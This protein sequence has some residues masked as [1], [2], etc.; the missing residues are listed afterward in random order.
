M[1][2][3]GSGRSRHGPSKYDEY[4][5]SGGSLV[6]K[7]G[8]G[9]ND[10]SELIEGTKALR[11]YA[12]SEASKSKEER[13]R[14]VAAALKR[15]GIDVDTSADSETIVAQLIKQ[16][17]NPKNG[18]SFSNEA[19]A[20]EKVCKVVAD[21]LN[22]EFTPG[23]SRNSHK[24]I[25]T[26]LGAVEVCRAVGEWAH[27]FAV[28]INTEFMAVHASVKNTLRAIKIYDEIM[29]K[30][31]NKMVDRVHKRG[32]EQL[33][34][35]LGPLGEVYTRAQNARRLA[36]ET[37]S[38]L[39]HVKLA[40][41]ARELEIAMR[42]E[43]ETNAL[44]K[45]LGVKPGT[46]AF[47]DTLAMSVSSIGTT[48]AIASK[49]HKAL[50]DVGVSLQQYLNSKDYRDLEK[51]LDSKVE[52]NEV[53]AKDLS[54]FLKAVE[55]LRESFGAPDREKLRDALREDIARHGGYDSD[56]D[57]ENAKKR[58]RY[59]K[60]ATAD[61][62]E[63]RQIQHDFATRMARHYDELLAAVKALGPELGDKIPISDRTDALRDALQRVSDL[64]ADNERIEL[65]LIGKFVGVATRETKEKFVNALQAVSNACSA[66]LELE[67]YRSVSSY[68]VRLKA[69]IDSIKKT[70]DFYSDVITKKFGG[71]DVSGGCD[72]SYKGG[73]DQDLPEI[74]RSGLSLTTS[75]NEFAY[76]YYVSKVRANLKQTSA[77]LEG[78]G[79]KYTELL[80]DAVAARLYALEQERIAII[81]QLTEGS[82]TFQ[83]VAWLPG[84]NATE[85]QKLSLS[86]LKKAV[87]V[88]YDT[89]IGFYRVLQGIDLYMKEFTSHITKDPDAVKEIKKILDG[90]P[91]IARWFSE[92]TGDALYK[93]F[94]GM[95]SADGADVVAAAALGT[96][97]HDAA[98]AEHYY[99]KIA[100]AEGAAVANAG[101][102]GIPQVGVQ[103]D[104]AEKVKKDV[105]SVIDN[106]QALKNLV[107][108][109]LR[110]GDVY[111]GSTL[112]QK[113]FL[114]PSE[115]YRYLI[116][117][118]KNSAMSVNTQA[119][120]LNCQL[121]GVAIAN[122]V[123][124][125]G[126]Y[127][128][129]V[130]GACSGNYKL[131][132]KYFAYTIKAMAAKILTV[133]GV[134]DLFE[135]TSP[136]YELTATRM[137]IGGAAENDPDVLE[138]A[139]ELYF[140]L[141][142]LAEFYRSYLR[143]KEANF[144]A[145]EYKIAM[146][147]DIDGTF[148]NLIQFIFV[149][150]ETAETGDYSDSELRMLI[151]IINNV[152]EFYQEKHPGQATKMALDAF[153]AEI[154]RRYG[155]LKKEDVAAYW[156]LITPRALTGPEQSILND[157]NYAILPEE[158]SIDSERLAP[159]DRFTVGARPR[160]IN[161]EP[162]NPATGRPFNA[163]FANQ[164][165]IANISGDVG[166][167]MLRGFR[168]KLDKD[169]NRT[170]VSTAFGKRQYALLLQ[171]AEA[172]LRKTASR[173]ERLK[174][175]FRLIQVSPVVSMDAGKAF[176][177]NETVVVGLNI[178]SAIESMLRRYSNAL[179]VMDPLKIERAI[180][181][182]LYLNTFGK[183]FNAAGDIIATPAA[184]AANR[185]DLLA[186]IVER[187]P[188]SANDITSYELSQDVAAV[189]VSKYDRYI[190]GG[191]ALTS[192]GAAANKVFGYTRG[193]PDV[194]SIDDILT[195]AGA[196]AVDGLVAAG[197][198]AAGLGYG[199]CNAAGDGNK[200]L[201]SD[202]IQGYDDKTEGA[203][204]E[205]ATKS[206]ETL[207][208]KVNAANIVAIRRYLQ[209]LRA[210]SRALTDYQLIM[211]DFVEFLFELTSSSS[212]LVGIQFSSTG[213]VLLD[214][215][216]LRDL[217]ESLLAD[218]KSY[219]EQFRSS[220]SK[221]AVKRFESKDSAGS[222]FWIEENLIDNIF[223]AVNPDTTTP[224]AKSLDG[225]SER[226]NK[227]FQGLNRDT[228]VSF[229]A[230]AN[231][232]WI[233]GNPGARD[234]VMALAG[235]ANYRRE[236]YGKTFSKLVYY[237]S[238]ANYVL[239]AGG[240]R[241]A[242][243]RSGLDYVD[244]QVVAGDHLAD[245]T[246]TARYPLI[247]LMRDGRPDPRNANLK[248]VRSVTDAA[249]P[250]LAGAAPTTTT[251]DFGL[252]TQ[253]SA[254][255]LLQGARS[256][257]FSFNQ[258]L[259]R[260]LSV[261]TDSAGGQ[262][263]YSQLIA[264]LANGTLSQS[265]MQPLGSAFPDIAGGAGGVVFG[266]R[267][268]PKPNALLFQSL[269]FILQ[270]LVKDVNPQNQI[271]DHLFMTLTDVPMYMKE[272][273]RANLP[274][275]AK[276]FD[277]LIQKGEF[278][279][280]ILQVRDVVNLTRPAQTA[281]YGVVGVFA[282]VGA[283]SSSTIVTADNTRG[284]VA[285]YPA[286][287]LNA[288]EDLTGTFGNLAANL[289]APT[290]KD[291]SDAMRTKLITII[292]NISAAAYTTST[293]ANEVLK[294]LGDAPIYMQ[295]QEG[296]FETYK[297]RY[298]K[299]PMTPIS[300]SLWFLGDI[301]RVSVVPF[302]VGSVADYNDSRL[303]PNKTLGTAEFK[304]LYGTRQLLAQS[305][306]V[307]W[308]QLV[309]VKSIVDQYN[310]GNAKRD[311][312]DVDGYLKF[313][314]NVVK[315]LR[316][317]TDMRNYKPLISTSNRLQIGTFIADAGAAKNVQSIIRNDSVPALA[318]MDMVDGI[319]SYIPATAAAAA[320]GSATWALKGGLSARVAQFMA[321]G[322]I[323]PQKLP[324]D[325]ANIV[326]NSNQEDRQKEIYSQI[327]AA[328]A[329][330]TTN[331][332]L[333]L[334]FNIIDMNIIPFN[335]H[336]M[337]RDIP[338]A[339]IYNYEYTFEQMVCSMYGRQA[340][341]LSD[342]AVTTKDYFLQLLADPYMTVSAEN[343]GSDRTQNG[344]AGF[345]GRIFRGDNDLG[346]GR[347][348]FLSD[349]LYNK[350]L[351]RSVYQSKNDYDEGGPTVG[352]GAARGRNAPELLGYLQ[353][354]VVA[355][356][357]AIATELAR[358]NQYT[359][360]QVRANM[361]AQITAVY[362]GIGWDAPL[363]AV[364]PQITQS[365][366][367]N[368]P[369]S[370]RT[371]ADLQNYLKGSVGSAGK[372][373]RIVIDQN[374]RNTFMINDVMVSGWLKTIAVELDTGAIINADS[375][376][377]LG[378]NAAAA[379]RAAGAGP[380]AGLHG[381]LYPIDPVGGPAAGA[382]VIPAAGGAA[383]VGARALIAATIAYHRAILGA[384]APA[385]ATYNAVAGGVAVKLSEVVAAFNAV[386]TVPER[387]A[388]EEWVLQR[389]V[390][391]VA[392]YFWINLKAAI[393]AFIAASGIERSIS[394][395]ISK[396][397]NVIR[398][399]NSDVNVDATIKARLAIL[400]ARFPIM[401]IFPSAI[402][403]TVPL[404]KIDV[405]T[406]VVGAGAANRGYTEY[407]PGQLT[408]L[409]NAEIAAPNGL[410][411]V[412]LRNFPIN[413]R[414]QGLGQTT[415]GGRSRKLTYIGTGD[416]EAAVNEV[417]LTPAMNGGIQSNKERLEAIG[418]A[419]FDTYLV[420][421]LFFITN[422]VRVI[423]AKLS[424]ELTQSRNVLIT[425][426]EAVA[427]SYTEYGSDPY[428]PNEVFNSTFGPSGTTARFNDKERI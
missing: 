4:Y 204:E 136:L 370:I 203:A 386:A 100:V 334:L 157:T 354:M 282:G 307:S 164:E 413:N 218:V 73:D 194:S 17:P 221:E 349:Q 99:Q 322:E 75:V 72:A 226:T 12:S 112:R 84:A 67:L 333:E 132:S 90:V 245:V 36:E 348:K 239:T 311:Q 161:G 377:Q 240:A 411:T 326:E 64:R 60:K 186:R 149:R 89:K 145:M 172:D 351:L 395:T 353:S 268:D 352:I 162:I 323:S 9:A 337:M 39:L 247:T 207:S 255:V 19:K 299:A 176:M 27:A 94:E 371:Y 121:S 392:T 272:A 315:G 165:A 82:P 146:L 119:A 296:A 101:L 2:V 358:I 295:T 3:Y 369:A 263:I 327:V 276:L 177:F 425:D 79:E 23:E 63:K 233:A 78:Y 151:S 362:A 166:R 388:G 128:G 137:I 376:M 35:E 105:S 175:A 340:S 22:D 196:E 291:V 289:P 260:Y 390:R 29:S 314:Q 14:R 343:Y 306:Q 127:F 183:S 47:A 6:S 368:A 213:K 278:I 363:W 26:S 109:F 258:L 223:N 241:V 267:G 384:R 134:Y 130:T 310:V 91:V 339:N 228:K 365:L 83:G 277:L 168:E 416:R 70:I 160:F 88:E 171:Q 96:A 153:V 312:V 49:V 265:V 401:R 32:D 116:D 372:G 139:A 414:G 102:L 385:L 193:A 319:A 421:N 341:K 417:V 356:P 135:R 399:W 43:S 393:I 163:P 61:M 367:V 270:R 273:Y 274:G 133:I 154:N 42:D 359:L 229:L 256:L 198:A 190:A 97:V 148:A 361:A 383:A 92:Q 174:I 248:F 387:N 140:R 147:P 150:S 330:G 324:E 20:Q 397:E 50:T 250:V 158:D 418:K 292:D 188:T 254:G 271:S 107:N 262:R 103:I 235:D 144:G 236:W 407:A 234:P 300:L 380:L 62:S 37:L 415:L 391:F 332:D 224:S 410:L 170:D 199:F 211:Q 374:L 51:V 56:E 80:G 382:A 249:I 181:D 30:Y 15:T 25:D 406:N 428:G 21:V 24:L 182:T 251:A 192:A 77:E 129:S 355:G 394:D 402:N 373:T 108:A 33:G 201:P 125:Y 189:N 215:K 34:S 55:T 184:G 10:E 338:L 331:R 328:M 279:K 111:G 45:K 220:L 335:V 308:D 400:L 303:F 389:A 409:I 53:S 8:G 18:K 412:A 285:D 301:E 187:I 59:E 197:A 85:A 54:K 214:F 118:V 366:M 269:A 44:V 318:N 288:L 191:A 346:M 141:P 329:A 208:S 195:F 281:G 40:P 113:S 230:A 98:G 104:Q 304:L 95:G 93:A 283:V 423:R 408:A 297:I 426:H 244:P 31:Y 138:G 28:G 231:A 180:M 71:E 167:E 205:F 65:A 321:A 222:I 375:D 427:S 264:G 286:N 238:G 403:A 11:E 106:F 257:M 5:G 227:V 41:A 290:A 342:T 131:E 159:S 58:S 293:A 143:T 298:G 87:L 345:V 52:N 206:K 122:S 266:A 325:I 178:L 13:I 216:K 86:K 320:R 313:I 126:S 246:N 169:F 185:A 350:S 404:A 275:F 219:F 156:K 294:E 237:D 424:R 347:P 114:K 357:N 317:L 232:A 1:E 110:I 379:A 152:F 209:A 202:F 316:F 422:V 173:E 76:F 81:A 7:R 68:F 344:S 225:I 212:G 46:G 419:R 360:V 57:D 210:S 420:R 405:I 253:L 66:I 280:Q 155:V 200:Y 398:Y 120:P 259:A 336:A 217:S 243:F 242:N 16:L 117:F 396:W 364:A 179:D 115:I 252:F 305:S 142:R 48:A 74:A 381:G 38:N 261:L 302:P 124:A 284:L 69:A 123:G 378:T 309:G 287:S